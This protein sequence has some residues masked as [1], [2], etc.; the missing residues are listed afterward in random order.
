[1]PNAIW[2]IFLTI[3]VSSLSSLEEIAGCLLQLKEE[4]VS[5]YTEPAQKRASY[6]HNVIALLSIFVPFDLA[7]RGIAVSKGFGS[8]RIQSHI[9]DETNQNTEN[10]RS[11]K[12]CLKIPSHDL[13]LSG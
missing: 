8:N 12:P 7:L 2:F 5:N 3:F 6:L 10:H 1:M 13:K 9:A 4:N 11:P